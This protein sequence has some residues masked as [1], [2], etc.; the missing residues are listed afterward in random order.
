MILH[1]ETLNVCVLGV[2]VGVY[3]LGFDTFSTGAKVTDCPFK[4]KM[5]KEETSATIPMGYA[6]DMFQW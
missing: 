1:D 3:L 4:F 2:G 5:W 6:Q